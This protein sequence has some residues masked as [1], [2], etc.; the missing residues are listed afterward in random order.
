M[1]IYPSPKLR[2]GLLNT[3]F[4][5]ADYIK[6]TGGL[7]R[8]ILSNLNGLTGNI[9]S[10]IDTI[11]T[12]K[13]GEVIQM[14]LFNPENSTLQNF[15]AS[16]GNNV[17]IFSEIIRSKSNNSQIYATF[18]A[19]ARVNGD[20]FDSWGSYMNNRNLSNNDEKTM[21]AKYMNINNEARNVAT[22]I[23]PLS[24]SRLNFDAN[25]NFRI[26]VGVYGSS[27][28]TIFFSRWNMTLMEIQN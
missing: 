21:C 19:E 22:P 5:S 20:G 9:Q 4:N 26:D 11:N 13:S 1:S 28:D 25:V 27:N 2:D 17:V 16:A 18:D 3:V 15:S 24:G 8:A 10:Q 23:F 12:Y 6:D 7:D 14:K